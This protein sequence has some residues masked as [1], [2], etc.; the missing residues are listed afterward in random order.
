MINDNYL[1]MYVV[2]PTLAQP[3]REGWD[4]TYEMLDYNYVV[5]FFYA[6]DVT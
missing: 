1:A 4:V 2:Q 6:Q 5:R 3:V